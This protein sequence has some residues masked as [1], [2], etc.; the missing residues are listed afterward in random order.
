MSLPID[1]II[2]IIDRNRPKPRS[3]IKFPYGICS[4]TVKKAHKVIKCDSVISVISG[5]T[6]DVMMSLILNTNTSKLT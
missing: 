5:F 6:V 2:S 4:K 3:C 1:H